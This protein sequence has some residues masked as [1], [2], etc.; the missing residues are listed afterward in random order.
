M[1]N[2]IVAEPA[3]LII[4]AMRSFT[5]AVQAAFL[6]FVAAAVAHSEEKLSALQTA[7]S[8][9]TVN[10]YVNTSAHWD[11]GTG[12][13]PFPEIL[14]PPAQWPQLNPGTEVN[15]VP[16]PST[17]ALFVLGALFLGWRGRKRKFIIKFW[18]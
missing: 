15:A 10:G 9:T 1:K 4:P 14:G 8:S 18:P 16:E 6:V 13:S 7:L 17:I 11:M 12:Y 2:V 3:V 5:M